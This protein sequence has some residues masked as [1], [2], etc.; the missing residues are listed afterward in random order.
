MRAHRIWWPIWSANGMQSVIFCLQFSL[1]TLCAIDEL[2]HIT[3]WVCRTHNLANAFNAAVECKWPLANELPA[4]RSKVVG[5]FR[6]KLHLTQTA[7]PPISQ[8][9]FGNQLR[10]AHR[11]TAIERFLLDELARYSTFGESCKLCMTYAVCG[12]FSNCFTFI[13]HLLNDE[14]NLSGKLEHRQ[15]LSGVQIAKLSSCR[16]KW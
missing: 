8:R 13:S 5:R 14:K 6:F 2:Q 3:N 16:M 12:S 1:V 7:D 11:T 10:D 15:F 4:C 9:L